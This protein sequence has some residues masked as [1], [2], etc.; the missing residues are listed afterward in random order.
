MLWLALTLWALLGMLDPSSRGYIAG[1]L[2]KRSFTQIY[3]FTTRRWHTRLWDALC[4]PDDDTAGIVRTFWAAL[5]WRLYDRA[6]LIAVAY[7]ILLLVGQWVA[8][9]LTWEGTDATLGTAVVL[10]A[11]PAWPDRA[12]TFGGLALVFLSWPASRWAAAREQVFLRKVAPWLPMIAFAGAFAA[13][14]AAAGVFA[15]LWLDERGR[16]RASR[17]AVTCLLPLCWLVLLTFLDWSEGDDDDRAIFLFLGVLPLLNALFDVISYAVTL[18]FIRLGLR[19]RWPFLWGSLDLAVALI[20]FFALG[21]F[22][23]IVIAFMNR[24]AGVQILDLGNLFLGITADPH[25]YWWLYLMVFST[26]LPTAI[27]GAISLLGIQGAL[28][29]ALRRPAAALLDGAPTS[30]V[31]AALAPL[32]VGT[33]WT[34]PFVLLGL[35]GWGL[36]MLGGAFVA[37]YLGI[38]LDNLLALATR[39][40]A[41]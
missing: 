41:F 1:T 29:Y 31:K 26:V 20:L 2:K 22:L 5:T 33:L 10:P 3:T 40:G 38:Y 7:P 25:T 14:F 27:H 16:P 24:I 37:R 36:W 13:A 15:V 6:L 34:I 18:T 28:P 4:D 8:G 35:I 32:A 11:A 30:E 21:A 23:T 19:S 39:I 17:L 9:G 12:V